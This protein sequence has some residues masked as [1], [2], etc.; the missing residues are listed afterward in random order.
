MA[1]ARPGV[2]GMVD[3]AATIGAGPLFWGASLINDHDC[4]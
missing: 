3:G 4:A 1:L 2:I